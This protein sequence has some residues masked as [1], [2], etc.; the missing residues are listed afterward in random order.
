M[1]N[2]SKKGGKLCPNEMKYL[3]LSFPHWLV[4]V[5]QQQQVCPCV[6]YEINNFISA[7]ILAYIESIKG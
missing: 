7:V 2:L 3:Q 1:E 5:P 4:L 6:A